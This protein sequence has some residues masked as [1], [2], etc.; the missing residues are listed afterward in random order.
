MFLSIPGNGFADVSYLYGADT[1]RDGRV[2]AR[3]D[4][5]RD[6]AEEIILASRNAP[7]L[8]IYARR[9]STNTVTLRLGAAG[10]IGARVD[11]VA[12]GRK[13]RRDVLGGEGFGTQNSRTLTIPIG[14]CAEIDDVRV[15]WPD[16]RIDALGRLVP[17]RYDLSPGA[18]R[19]LGPHV[20]G[21]APVIGRT[22]RLLEILDLG[23]GPVFV[24]LWAGWCSSCARAEPLLDGLAD[25]LEEVTI[26][27]LSVD[28]SDGPDRIR[29]RQ[30]ERRYRLASAEPAAIEEVRRIFGDLPPLPSGVL[31][32]GGR[33]LLVTAGVPTISDL[34]ARLPVKRS[35]STGWWALAAL[36]VLAH[37]TMFSRASIRRHSSR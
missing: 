28:P 36:P 2:F 19:D 14:A 31:I 34:R 16:G 20:A 21:D 22:T 35:S 30:K 4:L 10:A 8:S 18:R 25:R 3:A 5:D 37:L 24:T 23:P 12:C 26:V 27:G 15:R 9:P 7:I 6:G 11:G 1:D 32:D 33:V 29:E 13:I 17:G